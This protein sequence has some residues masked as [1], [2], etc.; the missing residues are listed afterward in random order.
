[1]FTQGSIS[2]R[3]GRADALSASCFPTEG[4]HAAD[5]EFMLKRGH[6]ALRRQSSVR[7]LSICSYTDIRNTP[8]I[9]DASY[10]ISPLNGSSSFGEVSFCASCLVQ[11][12]TEN[13]NNEVISSLGYIGFTLCNG[14]KKITCNSTKNKLLNGQ[15]SA[16]IRLCVSLL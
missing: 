2:H 7:R 13:T 8:A 11:D 14:F 6:W 16:V 1:M 9:P 10:G 3:G 15:V 12:I 5:A 4:F